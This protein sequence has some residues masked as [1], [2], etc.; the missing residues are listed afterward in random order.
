M[1][2][3]GEKLILLLESRNF[4]SSSVVATKKKEEKKENNLCS[5]YNPAPNDHAV[6]HELVHVLYWISLLA[7]FGLL[8]DP[9]HRG[10]G[11]GAYL[12]NMLF[13]FPVS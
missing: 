2:F 8:H 6:Y 7:D 4:K 9:V 13:D 10:W 12:V 11:V 5:A 3:I 1:K